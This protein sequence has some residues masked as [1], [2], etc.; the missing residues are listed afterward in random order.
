MCHELHEVF[1]S[2]TS[3]PGISPVVIRTVV[4]VALLVRPVVLT[5][6]ATRRPE[7]SAGTPDDLLALLF[8][9]L[10]ILV[11]CTPNVPEP[12]PLLS[13]CHVVPSVSISSELQV[14]SVLVESRTIFHGDFREVGVDCATRVYHVSHGIVLSALL[15]NGM[16]L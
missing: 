11:P 16:L 9:H 1:R 15:R 6:E 14:I 13:V 5:P 12:H 10:D 3:V 7:E 8:R 4:L 2:E